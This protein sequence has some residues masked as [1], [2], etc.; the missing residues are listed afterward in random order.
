MADL[1]AVMRGAPDIIMLPKVER[2]DHVVELDQQVSRLEQEYGL[3]PGVTELS[4]NIESAAGFV[5]AGEIV[6]ASSRVRAGIGGGEDMGVDLGVERTRAASEMAYVRAQFHLV[7]RAHDVVAIDM[8]YTW[9]D[10]DGCESDTRNARSLGYVAKSAVHP[11]HCAVINWV[12]TPQRDEAIA[13][14]RI[15]DAFEAAR[16]RGEARVELDGSLVEVP[17]YL[18]AKRIYARAVA[19]AVV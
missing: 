4:P 12:L 8:P 3:E 10:L 2:P 1:T 5:R 14:A 16:S 11:P 7:C 9:T 19:F 18:N 15:I 17:I 13:A 6:S